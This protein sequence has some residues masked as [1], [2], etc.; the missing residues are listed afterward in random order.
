MSFTI[1]K[2]DE[3]RYLRAVA[4]CGKNGFAI[5]PHGYLSFVTD[6]PMVSFV[7]ENRSDDYILVQTRKKNT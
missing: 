2:C 7:V 6:V 4:E 3:K 5:R 1:K